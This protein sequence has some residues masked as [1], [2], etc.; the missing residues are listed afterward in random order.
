MLKTVEPLERRAAVAAFSTLGL[1]LAGHAV[2]ETARDALFLRSLPAEQ[3]PWVYLIIAVV[4]L[5][6]A[7]ADPAFARGAERRE[8]LTM[9]LAGAALVT[10]ILWAVAD[11]V[12]AVSIWVLYVWTGVFGTVALIH[13]WLSLSGAFTVTQAKRL[14][15]F[16]GAG[17]LVG[18]IA[19]SALARV[20][21]SVT[22]TRNLVLL[23]AGCMAA[24][25]FSSHFVSRVLAKA[26]ERDAL[27]P[28]RPV[29]LPDAFAVLRGEPYVRRV[30]LFV[31]LSTIAV[32][33]A[34]YLF[35]REV[36]AAV[37]P[38]EL[39][40]FFATFYASLNVL[41]L[42]VQLGLVAWLLDR[43]GVP[44]TLAILP[45]LLFVGGLWAALFGGL[46]S[47]LFLRGTNGTLR[48]SLH[49]TATEVL[50]VPLPGAERDRAKTVA[51]VVGHRIGQAL[52]S[53]LILAAIW[54]FEPSDG[55]LAWT[56]TVAAG[57]TGWLALRSRGAYLEVFRR[58]LGTL[59]PAR[60]RMLP[61]LDGA[62][63]EALI[64]ALDS[65]RERE[66]LASLDV[67][68]AQSR[69][70]LVPALLLHHPSPRVVRRALAFFVEAGR[71]DFVPTA[72]RV[73]T[74]DPE[75]RAALLR[76]IAAAKPD[77][78]VLREALE[79]E[80]ARVRA[81]AL[82]ELAGL[83]K[84]SAAEADRRLE[85]LGS[86]APVRR[87]IAAA[88]AVRPCPALD[89]RLRALA[90]DEEVSVRAEAVHAMAARSD[91]AFFP[92]LLMS[93]RERALR[94]LARRG[95]VDAGEAGL[96]FLIHALDDAET[97]EDVRLHVPR[98][99]GRFPP[100]RAAALL[101]SRL[102]READPR[103][104]Y[105]MLRALGS[106]TR[107]RGGLALD[108]EELGALAQAELSRCRELVIWRAALPETNA[109]RCTP[110]ALVLRDLLDEELV[111][112]LERVFRTLAL[113]H[114]GEDFRSIQR[115]LGS[116]DPVVRASCEELLSEVLPHE[117]RRAL[118]EL[119]RGSTAPKVRMELAP[120]LGAMI[121][122]G[123]E[124][125]AAIAASLA[126]E[127]GYVELA[128]RV[129]ARV[130][131]LRSRGLGAVLIRALRRLGATRRAA[132]G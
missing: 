51:D 104:R 109:A 124:A 106:M 65:P 95:F 16:V 81:T 15:G 82:V 19:G 11:F 107:Q 89:A 52:A 85:A 120:A 46:A 35:K 103:A 102:G 108:P 32:T 20:L 13:F 55:A 5:A 12:S 17:A 27:R 61:P 14:F 54:F 57:L 86:E 68:R 40:S 62:A 21:V 84:I 60:Q 47:V 114:P 128:P 69:I 42:I 2:L 43:A 23:A 131:A 64:G 31:L 78:S 22:E 50:F 45:A 79:D 25:A 26:G 77:E 99:I 56:I 88:L 115:G 123:N 10:G 53:V 127:V 92:E 49:R 122:T 28:A 66:V 83:G 125:L 75:L 117:D 100:E 4:T 76:G 90:E 9:F 58:R 7:G 29:R 67:F 18:A 105:K 36:A 129:E 110:T 38:A 91:G 1:V 73:D 96:D 48:H 33:L 111:H 37:A 113:R 130:R 74:D 6:L 98:S 80:S 93:L 101:W 34:D 59:A 72:L 41:A 97:P 44:R 116:D 119:V 30:V 70:D 132:H 63:L 94:P 121:E 87:A 118:L 24:A 126:A 8:L 71:R 112:G 3:L 39:A